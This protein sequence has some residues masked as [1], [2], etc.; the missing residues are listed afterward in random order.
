MW[1]PLRSAANHVRSTFMPPKARTLMLPSGLRLHGQPQC[2]S[3]HHLAC[4]GDEVVDH[5]LLAQPVAAGDRVVE[6]VVERVVRLDRR[7]PARPRRQRCGCAWADLG[8]QSDGQ[9]GSASAAAIAA[10]RPAPPAPII[11]TSASK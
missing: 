10:R 9:P 7:R 8:D 5:V 6:M 1:K 11:R 3:L 2:S 4:I